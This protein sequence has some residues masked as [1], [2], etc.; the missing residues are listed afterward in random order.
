[1]KKLIAAATFATLAVAVPSVG[2]AQE[3]KAASPHTF[4][5]NL[6]LVSEYRYRGIAQTN[7]KPAVQGGFDYSHA[8]G[9][10]LGTWASNV[11]WLS[12]AGAGAVSNSLEWDMYGG[13]KGAVG[14][15]GYDVGLLYYY[16][17]GSYPAGFTSPNTLEVYGAATWKMFTLKYSHALTN[18][19]GFT[20]SKGAG[21]IDLSA[22]Y[23]VGGGYTLVGHYGHQSVPSTAGRAKSDCSYSDWKVGVTTEVA[24]MTV[25]LSYIDTDAKGNG[26]QCYRN[27]FN[28]DLG[29]G[30]VVLSVGKTF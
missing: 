3:K 18:L 4:T 20:D 26:G 23:E 10:Y 16:Y 15:L 2:M 28:R 25:G 7:A 14:D 30:N 12:D 1:M 9:V 19:F 8:S 17:P 13:Y 11:S 21:Y 5:G 27:A 29:K 24:G 22:S 6:N